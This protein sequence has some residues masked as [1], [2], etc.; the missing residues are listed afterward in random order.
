MTQETST[1][2]PHLCAAQGELLGTQWDSEK[3]RGDRSCP[4]AGENWKFY[5]LGKR[6]RNCVAKCSFS[7]SRLWRVSYTYNHIYISSRMNNKLN[8]WNQQRMSTSRTIRP[9]Y[10]WRWN[11]RSAVAT[12]P[13]GCWRR[14][15]DATAKLAAWP[16]PWCSMVRT[17]AQYQALHIQK[18]E[19]IFC[20]MLQVDWIIIWVFFELASSRVLQNTYWNQISNTIGY[21]GKYLLWLHVSIHLPTYAHTCFTL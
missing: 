20:F 1:N 11:S 7:R 19:R 6:C 2:E 3:L 14:E 21:C 18:P 12:W 16:V 10:R 8:F 15:S 17:G 9:W 5:D 13:R 4:S